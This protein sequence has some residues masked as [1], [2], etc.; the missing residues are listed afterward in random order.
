[1]NMIEKII[2]NKVVGVIRADSEA[3]ALKIVDACVKGGLKVIEVTFTIPNAIN[4]IS[5]IQKSFGDKIILGAGT[6]LDV[7]TTKDAI[8]AGCKFIVSPGF[9]LKTALYC[10]QNN[11]PYIPGCMT[12]TEM[13]TAINHGADLVKLF[14]GD[15]F[16]PTFVKSIKGPLPNIKIMPTGGVDLDN[17]LEWFKNGAACV[18]IG[19]ALT[20]Y[21]KTNQYD[22]I[23]E[24]AK[25]YID[26]VKEV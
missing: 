4:V 1:M 19:S 22:K 18:G 17:I 23:T 24:V 20:N 11:I 9:H 13:M 7:E 2:A 10:N 26:K 12:V 6:V 5:S 14:P 8:D 21:A 3:Q 16:G 25:A 15:F